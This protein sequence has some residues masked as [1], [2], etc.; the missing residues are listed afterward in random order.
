M[1]RVRG[2]GWAAGRS[3]HAGQGRGGRGGR[4]WHPGGSR[5]RGRGRR[6]VGGAGR[7]GLRLRLRKS[8]GPQALQEQRYKRSGDWQ[9]SVWLGLDRKPRVLQKGSGTSRVL[10]NTP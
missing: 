7:L 8:F 6:G 5:R 9:S 3:L 4:F 1:G 2:G 10:M